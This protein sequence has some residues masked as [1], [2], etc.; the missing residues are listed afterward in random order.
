MRRRQ[1]SEVGHN[2]PN[3]IQI[4]GDSSAGVGSWMEARY[5]TSSHPDGQPTNDQI[6]KGKYHHKGMPMKGCF[7]GGR[8]YKSDQTFVK[9]HLLNHK[10]GGMA[11]EENL[12]PITQKGNK[13]HETQVE[14]RGLRVVKRV[15][16]DHDLMYYKVTVRETSGPEEITHPTSGLGEGFYQVKTTFRCEVADYNYCEDDTVRRN[17]IQTIDVPSEFMYHTGN[18]AFDRIIKRDPYCQRP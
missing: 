2:Q 11:T 15:N 8:G 14:Q 6:Q 10:L 7:V 18:Q 4:P 16:N 9:G 17:P 3:T 13:R 5:L 1:L 12:F